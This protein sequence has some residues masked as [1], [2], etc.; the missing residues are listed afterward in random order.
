MRSWNFL[1]F[2]SQNFNTSLSNIYLFYKMRSWNFYFL[3]LRIS[4]LLCP[5]FIYFTK[6]GLGIFIFY[7]SEFQHFFVQYLFILQ[8]EVLDFL[9]FISQNFNTSLSNIYLFQKMRY[10]IFIFIFFRI[11]TLLF[12]IFIYFRNWGLAFLV[13]LFFRISTL[14]CPIFIYFKKWGLA[15]FKLTFQIFNNSW[16][17]NGYANYIVCCACVIDLTQLLSIFTNFYNY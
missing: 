9:Y 1:Y 11:S 13:F 6:W 5:I 16:G 10:G 8:N 2:I 17:I 3:F 7:F 4:T 15:F 14:L 12:R